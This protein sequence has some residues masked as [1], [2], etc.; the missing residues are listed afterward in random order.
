[1]PPGD[2]EQ[3]IKR[4]LDLGVP[5]EIVQQR[6]KQK[7]PEYGRKTGAGFIQNLTRN[8]GETVGGIGDLLQLSA[9]SRPDILNPQGSV[10]NQ[11]NMVGAISQIPGQLAGEIGK[12]ASDPVKYTYEN[13]L[14]VLLSLYPGIKTG[15]TLTKTSSRYV[16]TGQKI[17]KAGESIGVIPEQ[18]V[19]ELFGKYFSP[20]EIPN[21]LR[22]AKI[23]S[24]LAGEFDK[25]IRGVAERK[26]KITKPKL[27]DP[28]TG[29]EL[30]EERI[31]QRTQGKVEK[32]KQATPE[33]RTRQEIGSQMSKILHDL[34]PELEKLD[35]AFGK[36]AKVGGAI[37]KIFP[38][39][40]G[41]AVGYYLLNRFFGSR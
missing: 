34:S 8:A 12:F 14:D 28:V 23:P 37:K 30:L 17:G 18:Q 4:A 5:S 1:M 39:G 24:D 11:M 31:S 40:F 25:L 21:I 26:G 33:Q 36:K 41:G 16:R 3:R 22:R 10:Q 2:I 13:P 7:Y 27:N 15:K 35:K 19:S 32:G 9:Q 38:F 29:K 6:V 20:E